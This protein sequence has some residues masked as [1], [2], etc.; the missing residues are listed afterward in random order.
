MCVYLYMC[1]YMCI[2]VCE[3][4]VVGARSVDFI[5]LCMRVFAIC[6][7]RVFKYPGE[8]YDQKCWTALL[9]IVG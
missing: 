4:R 6:L 5:C 2:C 3:L 8:G 7:S 1:V 9:V